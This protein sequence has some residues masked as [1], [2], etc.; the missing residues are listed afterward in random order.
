MKVRVSEKLVWLGVI[1]TLTLV[2]AAGVGAQPGEFVKGVLQPLADGFPRRAIVLIVVDEA[3]S[4]DGIYGRTMQQ[5]LKGISPVPI[6]VSDEPAAAM[7]T[8][9]KLK[10]TPDR[11]GGKEGHY[12]II[13][14]CWG[15]SSDT[16]GEPITKELGLDVSDMNMVIITEFFP[17]TMVQRKNAPWGRKF[18][19]LVAWAK[20][21]PGKLRRTTDAV[22][23]GQDIAG[24][25][26]MKH[27]GIK[28]VKLP[29]PS[30]QDGLAAVG[31]GQSDIQISSFGNVM[32]HVLAGKM[33]IS[34]VFGSSVPP[35][36]DKDPGV[37]TTE[38]EGIT[39][40]SPVGVQM[41]FAVPKQ[42]PQAHIDWLFKLFKAGASTDVYK[43]REKTIPGFRLNIVNG[44]DAN[45]MKMEFYN[46][47]DP[48]IRE[49]E[50]HVDQQK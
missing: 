14:N 18:K 22:G 10:E 40:L 44:K 19:D 47:C 25:A 20:A 50:L 6:A 27:F 12:P 17:Y 24:T 3:G 16:L 31:A 30:I 15:A 35:P 37:S 45:A 9:L 29:Q 33:D 41:G 46:F 11:D 5:A 4:R 32:S 23:S 1:L 36:F 48:I 38:A 7:G 13:V 49:L 26:M 42:V 28:D 34:L 2:M 21:N 39:F 8:Y 43:Q